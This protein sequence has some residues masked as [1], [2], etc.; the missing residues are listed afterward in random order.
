MKSV[1]ASFAYYRDADLAVEQLDKRGFD[2]KQI[3]AVTRAQVME[4]YLNRYTRLGWRT[5]TGAFSGATLGGL[6]GLLVG[7]GAIK[8][9][10]L[11]PLLV[12]GALSS[13]LG[14]ATLGSGLGAA[15]GGLVGALVNLGVPHKEAEGYK[16]EVKHGKVIIAVH[17]DSRF[18][19]IQR[20]LC[21]L[22]AENV[23]VYP[24][25]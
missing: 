6:T 25:N 11:G 23:C 1:I 9:P 12:A 3:S 21:E 4:A 19:E 5:V 14:S 2:E 17:H 7:I 13:V 10:G 20:V 22:G 18:E 24:V 16:E 15:A 8:V